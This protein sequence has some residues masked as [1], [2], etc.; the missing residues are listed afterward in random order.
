MVAYV[1]RLQ[2]ALCVYTHA[3]THTHTPAVSICVKNTKLLNFFP[4]HHVLLK[5]I[6]MLHFIYW[7]QST[8]ALVWSSVEKF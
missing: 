5:N 6:F 1:L 3:R 4:N 7:G 2:R 8:T